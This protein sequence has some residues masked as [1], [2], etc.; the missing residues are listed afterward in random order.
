MVNKKYNQAAF[1]LSAAELKQLPQD[2]GNEVAFIG[3]S[4]S[5]KSSAI[6]T[7]TG[8]KNLAIASKTPGRTQTINLF[9]LDENNRLVD[10]PGYGYTKAPITVSQRWM[11]TVNNYL[12]TRKCLRGLI[13]IMDIRHPLKEQDVRLLEWSVQCKLPVHI[14]LTKSDKLKRNPALNTLKQVQEEINK[15][16]DLV[17]VQLFSSHDQTGLDEACQKL[18]NWFGYAEQN[19]H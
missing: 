18:D 12:K 7:I 17:S 13:L 16:G 14:L 15:Y 19:L 3:R 11:E 10:L 4:N 2:S 9:T 8:I 5:G 6:N 1:L